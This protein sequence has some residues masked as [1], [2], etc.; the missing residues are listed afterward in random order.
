MSIILLKECI[1]LCSFLQEHGKEIDY[2]S[3]HWFG[4]FVEANF[5]THFGLLTLIT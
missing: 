3:L 4:V 5:G 2:S 1:F